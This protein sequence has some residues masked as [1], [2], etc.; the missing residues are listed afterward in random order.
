MKAEKQSKRW[1]RDSEM[2]KKKKKI[3]VS[4]V[5]MWLADEEQYRARIK[6][7]KR[8]WKPTF[9]AILNERNQ[10]IEERS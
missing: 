5:R 8:S 3:S 4:R 2:S 7:K 1:G 10:G 6:K 9:W